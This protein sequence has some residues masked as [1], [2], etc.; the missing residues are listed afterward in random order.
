[1]EFFIIFSCVAIPAVSGAAQLPQPARTSVAGR[2]YFLLGGRGFGLSELNASLKNSGY[3]G[4]SNP[5]VSFGGGGHALLN[6]LLIGGEGHSLIE[7]TAAGPGYETKL[8]GGYALFDIGYVVYSKGGLNIY[9]FL[10]LG[11]GGIGLEITGDQSAEFEDILKNPGRMS[12]VSTYGFVIS[13]NLGADSLIK[14][15]GKGGSGGGFVAGA[16]AGFIWSPAKSKWEMPGL[17]IPGGP[18]IGFTGFYV[19]FLF[20]GGGGQ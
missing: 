8:S 7:K 5:L 14:I 12:K 4:Y 19:Q 20:G 3:S 1:L 6:R 15:G 2:G 11:G 17:T 18:N 9:P 13:L 16:R 10:G